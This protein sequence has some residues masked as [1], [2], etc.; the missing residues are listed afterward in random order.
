MINQKD[1]A[2]QFEKIFTSEEVHEFYEEWKLSKNP[3]EPEEDNLPVWLKVILV[4]IL[5]FVIS[6]LSLVFTR[7]YRG[8][9]EQE[10]K[11]IGYKTELVTYV[12]KSGDII[13]AWYVPIDQVTD[14]TKQFLYNEGKNLLKALK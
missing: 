10:V 7:E 11:Q 6:V 4:S 9:V 2:E 13:K 1:I 12:W 8:Y 5:V 14:T 3:E